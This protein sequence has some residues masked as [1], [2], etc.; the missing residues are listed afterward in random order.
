MEFK[1]D[2]SP[3]RCVMAPEL[4]IQSAASKSLLRRIWLYILL[5]LPP[6]VLM[7]LYYIL[8]DRK[9]IMDWVLANISLPYRDMAAQITAFGPFQ[10]FSVAEMLITFLI[11]WALYFI[12]KSIIILKRSSNRLLNLGH[13]FYIIAVIA[14]YIVAAHFW[15]WDSGYHSTSLAEKT[16]LDS[17]GI[18]T[19]QLTEVT[20]YFAEK[21]NELSSHVKRDADNRFHESRQTCFTPGKDLYTNI[22][23]EFPALEGS[24][25][26][27][28]AMMYSKLMSASGFSGIYIALTGEMNINIDI[29]A[30][31]I[32]VTIAHEMSH[33]RGVNSEA[34]ANFASIAACITSD[35]PIYEYS[36]YLLGLIYLTNDLSKADPHA[37]G[38]IT[39]TFNENVTQDWNENNDYWNSRETP[40]T[41]AVT[42]MYDSYL[43]S[44][45]VAAGVRSYNDCVV[46]LVSWIQNSGRSRSG[47]YVEKRV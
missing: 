10:Y 6:A 23:K 5:A 31:F 39:S 21:A 30:P 17:G 29:P 40:A 12:V 14:L 25:S 34:E 36:G 4:K 18:T 38:Q 20:R 28:K 3:Q 7:A 32:P 41:E 33:Q 26:V 11:L 35:N 13:R 22:V 47:F 45:G 43:K 16:D 44:N 9:H 8:N 24:N 42:T 1:Y 19:E 2:T 15:M 37:Y 27:P 46:M